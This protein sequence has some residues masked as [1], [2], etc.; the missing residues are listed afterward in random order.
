MCRLSSSTCAIS[1]CCARVSSAPAPAHRSA[2]SLA[3]GASCSACPGVHGDAGDSPGGGGGAG[4]W[5]WGEETVRRRG[6]AEGERGGGRT[7][8]LSRANSA[9]AAAAALEVRLRPTAVGPLRA[10]AKSAVAS[11]RAAL[12]CQGGDGRAGAG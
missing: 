12:P 1:A 4:P 3:A 7:L 6:E 9:A 8:L 11:S 5:R 2:T 10:S